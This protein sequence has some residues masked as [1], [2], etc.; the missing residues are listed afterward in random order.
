[1][2]A[3]LQDDQRECRGSGEQD[4]AGPAADNA[5]KEG[6]PFLQEKGSAEGMLQSAHVVDDN[7]VTAAVAI[8]PGRAAQQV[9]DAMASTRTA[10]LASLAEQADLRWVRLHARF[11]STTKNEL[12]PSG[13]GHVHVLGRYHCYI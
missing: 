11:G 10:E 3:K 4:A 5:G 6:T 12:F 7:A 9:D 1:M 8:S 13:T 2:T